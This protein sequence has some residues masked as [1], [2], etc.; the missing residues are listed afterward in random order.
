MITFT[1]ASPPLPFT[2]RSV[3]SSSYEHD[4]G[5][6]GDGDGVGDGV[7]DG[8]GGGVAVAAACV[9]FTGRP[10]IVTATERGAVL[11]FRSAVSVMSA[12][13]LPDAVESVTHE[14]GELVVQLQPMSVVTSTP[15]LLPGAGMVNVAGLTEKVQGDAAWVIATWLPLMLTLP[16]RAVPCGLE[17]AVRVID[18]SP[19]PDVGET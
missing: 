17:V 12:L 5:G 14:A 4:D 1:V 6:V 7:G 15:T 2:A 18:D 13:P 9:M 11:L 3:G 10:A 16:F 8:E 19:W